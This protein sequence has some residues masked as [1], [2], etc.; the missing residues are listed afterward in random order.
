MAPKL[1]I[2]RKAQAINKQHSDSFANG[3]PKSLFSVTVKTTARN[4]YVK[5]TRRNDTQL[6]Y[7]FVIKYQSKTG[8]WRCEDQN[9]FPYVCTTDLTWNESN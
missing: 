1:L 3:N 6:L 8:S 7:Y 4:G 2:Y 9:K 5:G